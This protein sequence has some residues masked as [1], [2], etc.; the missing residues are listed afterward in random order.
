MLFRSTQHP[1]PFQVMLEGRMPI[2]VT[3][4][5]GELGPEGSDSS[6]QQLQVEIRATFPE[7][8]QGNLKIVTEGAEMQ[9]PPLTSEVL[10]QVRSQMPSLIQTGHSALCQY[11]PE[12]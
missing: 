9:H 8:I 11:I 4:M 5:S 7:T 2:T 6:K 3:P 10:A 12:L 1:V